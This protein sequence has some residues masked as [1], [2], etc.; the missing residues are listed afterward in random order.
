MSTRRS[1]RGSSS[2]SYSRNDSA[3]ATVRDGGVHQAN[4][5][6]RHGVPAAASRKAGDDE[7]EEEEDPAEQFNF[8]NVPHKF[9][10]VAYTFKLNQNDLYKWESID[11][12]ARNQCVKAVSRL[13]LFK[14]S[15]REIIKQN[16]VLDALE[17]LDK[18][19]RKLANAVLFHVQGQLF[20][21][22][23]YVIVSTENIIGAKGLVPKSGTTAEYFLT[24]GLQDPQLLKILNNAC[25]NPSYQAF[26]IVVLLA[27][28]TAPQRKLQVRDILTYVRQID[29]RFP[30]SISANS[31]VT[32][33]TSGG[34][35]DLG[36][37]FLGLI[38]QMK[39]VLNFY[40][41]QSNMYPSHFLFI[42]YRYQI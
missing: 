40:L 22:M 1:A 42:P 29:P 18:N 7:E 24:N 4:K 16:Q 12:A 30:A 28:Y 20:N 8:A 13:F 2:S 9:D 3:D 17:K 33:S 34:I 15:R 26:L 23:G 25:L 5:R 6:V 37:D 27:I 32:G 19:Y 31:K 35:G 41:P 21:A 10:P 14:G 11:E 39:K 38:H 36:A